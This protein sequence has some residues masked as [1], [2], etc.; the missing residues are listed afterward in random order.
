MCGRLYVSLLF[1]TWTTIC[2]GGCQ[3]Q[4]WFPASTSGSNGWMT[5]SKARASPRTAFLKIDTRLRSRSPAWSGA[6]VIDPGV[7]R[8]A[9][10][11]A[12]LSGR[13]GL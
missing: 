6:D 1:M 7:R 4:P 5:S 12:D 8:S 11:R 13:T 2:F 9:I 3:G 10:I